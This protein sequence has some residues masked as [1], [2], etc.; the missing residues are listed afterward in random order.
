MAKMRLQRRQIFWRS[1]RSTMS[2]R[3]HASAGHGA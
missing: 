1:G 2:T 3:R